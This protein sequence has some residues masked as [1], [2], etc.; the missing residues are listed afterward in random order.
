MGH[1]VQRLGS[2]LADSKAHHRL[3]QS[4][5]GERDANARAIGADGPH[6]P[7]R[8]AHKLLPVIPVAVLYGG[9]KSLSDVW[10]MNNFGQ[11]MAQPAS[12]SRQVQRCR[13]CGGG[14]QRRVAR[15]DSSRPSRR[16]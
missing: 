14:R 5:R 15:S 4:E 3:E 6:G 1:D 12:Q 11:I 2:N 7:A 8:L 9:G 10:G 16:V 13:V